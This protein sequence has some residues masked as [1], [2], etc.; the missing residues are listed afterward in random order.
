MREIVLKTKE[1][2]KH[3]KDFTALNRVNITVYREDIYGLIGRNV[4]RYELKTAFI[5]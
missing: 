5:I 1:L 2:S 4:P 3:Y